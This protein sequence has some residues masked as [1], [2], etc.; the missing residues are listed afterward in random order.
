MPIPHEAGGQQGMDVYHRA[1]LAN[2]QHHR[3]RGGNG[4]GP[5]SSGRVPDASTGL[6][7]SRPISLT[8]DLGS[9]VMPSDSTR[10]SIRRAGTPR[11][12]RVAT[13]DVRAAS[14]GISALTNAAGIERSRSGDADSGWPCRS[15]RVDTA[16]GGHR[17]VS[18]RS[19]V[20]SFPKDHAV[21][22]LMGLRHARQ[23]AGQ[24]T[25]LPD[26]LP[27]APVKVGLARTVTPT[28]CVRVGSAS[29]G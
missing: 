3:V 22:A 2:L 18:F 8:R 24:C 9:R 17:D 26:E 14:A 7:R 23:Q 19:T 11:R 27:L 21:A 29:C 12:Q 20:R 10:F 5:A 4:Y 15:G 25:T 1:A 28:S 16:G 6:S 13:T